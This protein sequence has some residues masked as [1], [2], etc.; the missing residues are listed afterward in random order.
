MKVSARLT[1]DGFARAEALANDVRR[2]V[3]ER[4]QARIAQRA[5]GTSATR[6][7]QAI[8]PPAGTQRTR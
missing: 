2:R 5:A 7:P 8:E 6:T 4:V 1:G 3:I